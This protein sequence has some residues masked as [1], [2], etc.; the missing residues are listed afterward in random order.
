VKDN[1]RKFTMRAG[2]ASIV[3]G[4]LSIALVDP[5]GVDIAA[6][7]P[8]ITAFIAIAGMIGMHYFE[9]DRT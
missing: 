1:L 8:I 7:N 5:K 4:T 9:S 6:D 2:I 3:F